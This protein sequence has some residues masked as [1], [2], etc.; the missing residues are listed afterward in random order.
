METSDDSKKQEKALEI[1]EI[2]VGPTSDP[3]SFLP[4]TPK[5]SINITIRT[6]GQAADAELL[7]K[8]FALANGATVGIKSVRLDNS[9][10]GE[11]LIRLQNDAPWEPGRYLVEVTLNGKLSGHRELEIYPEKVES[12]E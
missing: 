7:T 12:I 10:A 6:T 11:Q 1:T 2:L 8:V 4:M 5:D 9:S 3:T